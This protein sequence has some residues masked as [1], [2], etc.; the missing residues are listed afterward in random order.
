MKTLIVMLCLLS[1]LTAQT[2]KKFKNVVIE[3]ENK[4]MFVNWVRTDTSLLIYETIVDKNKPDKPTESYWWAK[5]DKGFWFTNLPK[6]MNIYIE[7]V[8]QGDISWMNLPNVSKETICIGFNSEL[9]FKKF[10]YWIND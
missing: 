1:S 8:K 10:S 2:T 9:L 6:D 4:L 7:N 3:T 5:K